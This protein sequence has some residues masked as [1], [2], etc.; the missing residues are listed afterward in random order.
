MSEK[1]TWNEKSDIKNIIGIVSGKGG[2]GK[3]Y[4]TGML[5]TTL[6]R[7]GFRVGIL[8][9]DVTGPSIPHMFNVN[10]GVYGDEK[11][12][13]PAIT[14]TLNIKVISSSLLLSEGEDPIMWRGPL[15]GD[16]VTQFFT[17]VNWGEL[18]YLLIDFPPGTSDVALS[19]YENIPINGIILVT[20]PQQMVQTIVK[21][22][23]NMAKEMKIPLLGV[24][25]N[26][27]YVAN[28]LNGEKIYLY[29]ENSIQ[30][31]ASEFN[32]KVLGQLPFEPSNTKYIDQG[33]I[34]HSD[35]SLFE[36]I[37]SQLMEE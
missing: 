20:T 1:K 33:K 24:I 5:A 22:T 26:M 4:T 36:V 11:S 12:I 18:D 10:D 15:I 13:F 23:L 8:D 9:G 3:S 28:P 30:S 34:E 6:A 7:Q 17:V 27:A 35:T 14:K 37:A 16:L 19:A 2:V 31:I 25:E 21:K 32:L 29:G